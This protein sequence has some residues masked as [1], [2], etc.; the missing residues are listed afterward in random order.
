MKSLIFDW[1]RPLVDGL[2]TDRILAFYKNMIAKG[3][4]KEVSSVGPANSA[5]DLDVASNRGISLDV[6]RQEV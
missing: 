4:I 6:P 5:A 1:I 2:I 3:Q